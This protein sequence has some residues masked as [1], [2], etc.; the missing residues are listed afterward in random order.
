LGLM[1]TGA[2]LIFYLISTN[3]QKGSSG[4]LPGWDKWKQFSPWRS[5]LR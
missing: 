5:S 4:E 1:N 3:L 2:N